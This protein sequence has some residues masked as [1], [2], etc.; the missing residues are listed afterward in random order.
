MFMNTKFRSIVRKP[1]IEAP[2]DV[3]K[4][5]R[6]KSILKKGPAK[7]SSNTLVIFEE[8]KKYNKE[9]MDTMK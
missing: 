4:C 7:E 3:D 9:R 2:H 8:I 6:G 5:I 1:P